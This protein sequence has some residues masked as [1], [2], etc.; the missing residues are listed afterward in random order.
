[1]NKNIIVSF[2]VLSLALTLS[3]A[4]CNTNNNANATNN[5]T[6]V[7]AT[8]VASSTANSEESNKKLL[9]YAITTGPKDSKVTIIE[10]SDFQCPACRSIQPNFKQ[11]VEKYR[12]QVQFGYVPYPL[13]YHENALPAAKAVEAAQIQGKGWEMYEKLFEGDSLDITK[14]DQV[15]KDLG[16][17]MDKFNSDK[18]STDVANKITNVQAL[19][20]NLN[21]QGTPTFYINGVEFTGNPT[22][23]GFET[24]IKQLLGK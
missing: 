20:D 9:E 2:F 1:M 4:G 8:A 11:V 16:L 19:L 18:D 12:D 7:S 3:G 22:L 17:D 15:A 21:L 5:T 13:S 23:A 10:A 24:Q 14:I 6:N